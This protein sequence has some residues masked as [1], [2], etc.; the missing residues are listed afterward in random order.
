MIMRYD[1]QTVMYNDAEDT[2]DHHNTTPLESTA[3]THNLVELDSE[4]TAEYS[5]DTNPQS[6]LVKLQEYFQ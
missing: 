1:N 2:P 5:K 3:P 4:K 6:D